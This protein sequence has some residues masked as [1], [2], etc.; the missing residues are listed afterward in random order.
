MES[1]FHLC[2]EPLPAHRTGSKHGPEA[3]S[4]SPTISPELAPPCGPSHSWNNRQP[5]FD[6]SRTVLSRIFQAS[7]APPELRRISGRTKFLRYPP[8][9]EGKR[10]ASSSPRPAFASASP[11]G[12][13]LKHRPG[14]VLVPRGSARIGLHFVNFEGQ[15]ERRPG[16]NRWSLQQMHRSMPCQTWP[17]SG[18]LNRRSR[19]EL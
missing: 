11:D 1:T 5:P 3:R 17:G 7:Y 18:Q 6:N 14:A 16:H 10:C 13:L 9:F 8:A 19:P 2:V 15:T 4:G 12:G